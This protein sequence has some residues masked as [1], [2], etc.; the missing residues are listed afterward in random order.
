[1]VSL[2]LNRKKAHVLI[3]QYIIHQVTVNNQ[4]PSLTTNLL[5]LSRS[6][7]TSFAFFHN[8]MVGPV[9]YSGVT[10]APFSISNGVKQDCVL[11]SVLFNLFF[12]CV[13]RDTLGDL[14]RWVYL[15]YRLDGSLFNLRRLDAT[16]KTTEIL[17]QEAPFAGDCALMTHK[18]SE[19]QTL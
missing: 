17:L 4:L 11:T 19:P 9:L 15:R 2:I 6:W 10:S 18:K 1:M 12:A 14:H 8:G 13:P 7:S 16:N 5:L 3:P